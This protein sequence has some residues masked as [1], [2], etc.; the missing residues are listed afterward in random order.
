MKKVVYISWMPL[1]EKVERDWY[2]SYLREHGVPVA[3]WDV[4]GL[5]MGDGKT[6]GQSRDY[7]VKVESYQHLEQLLAATDSA[8]TNFVMIVNYERRFNRLFRVL[9]RF[10]CRLF[11]FEWGNFPIKDRGRARKLGAL[12]RNPLKLI[13][14]VGTKVRGAVASRLFP[15]K[16]FDVVF[17]AGY[18]SIAMHPKAGIKIPVNLCDYDNYK[19]TDRK[20]GRLVAEP[21]CI[22]LDINLAFQSDIK[23]VGWD[24]IDP[25][26]YAT[27]LERFFDMVEER[28]GIHVVIAAHPKAEYGDSYFNR[29][30]FKGVTA[31]LVRDAEF[32]IS[33]HSTAISYA[34]LGRKP[35]IFC[36]SDEMERIY[37][38]TIVGWI[39]DFAEY[40]HQPL[41]NIDHVVTPGEIEVRQPDI[42]RYD[43]YKYNYLTTPESEH[44]VTRDIFFD[45]ITA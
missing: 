40:L 31:E 4:T 11:F 15:V 22:F 28:Y 1:S 17:A 42:E 29:R 30:A 19:I 32:V 12:L 18:A 20:Q 23:L 37:R 36:Y 44:R 9:N 26:I 45:A 38:N 6:E 21:Y 39:A 16:P 2:I 8:L 27:S 13:R 25:A 3:Y 24:Y 5:L 33:H 10:D 14:E 7:R 34:V 35:L 43:L 41:Y